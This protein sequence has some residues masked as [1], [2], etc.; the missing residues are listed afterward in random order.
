[1]WHEIN[2]DKD[3]EKFMVEM[4]FFHDG[5]TRSLNIQAVHLWIRICV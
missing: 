5:C 1:M 4:Q 3:I 2:F